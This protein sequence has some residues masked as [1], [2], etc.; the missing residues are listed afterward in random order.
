MDDGCN[1]ITHTTWFN[2]KPPAKTG[3]FLIYFNQQRFILR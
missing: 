1:N 3:G 2:K